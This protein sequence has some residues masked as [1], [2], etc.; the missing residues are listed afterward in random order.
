[1]ISDVAFI[2]ISATVAGLLGIAA[3][4]AVLQERAARKATA[5]AEADGAGGAL[6]A[7]D[8]YGPSGPPAIG[9]GC[10]PR[11]QPRG[12]RGERLW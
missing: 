1:M 7:A 4:V 10:H 12:D 2:V 8:K 5:A 3:A 11:R 9:P 6:T